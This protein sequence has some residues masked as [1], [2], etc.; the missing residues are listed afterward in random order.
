MTK[1]RKPLPSAVPAASLVLTLC[2]AGAPLLA[3]A[4]AAHA[5]A[6]SAAECPDLTGTFEPRSTEWIDTFYFDAPRPRRGQSPQFATLQR[7]GDGYTLSWLMPK[8][9]VLAQARALAGRDPRSYGI[10]LDMVLRDPA[11]PLP[12]GVSAQEWMNRTAHYGPVFR[13]DAA[14]PLTQ[15]EDG[16]FLIA[17]TPDLSLW[18]GRARDGALLLKRKEQKIFRVLSERYFTT[19]GIPLWSSSRQ[20]IWPAAAALD[21]TPLSAEELPAGQ[22]P[23]SRIAPCQ[24]TEVHETLFFQR[25]Q[26]QLPTGVTLENHSSSILSGRLRPDG[27][28]EPTPYSVTVA[29]PDAAGIAQVA[30]HLRSDPLI[31]R[32]DGQ[33]T[34][35]LWDGR[36]MVEFRMQ[37][38]PTKDK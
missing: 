13:Y 10:W 8:E 32:I 22:R 17:G 33:E 2:L 27:T 20:E 37:V 16:W 11:I 36:L 6:P 5:A 38:A 25:L 12:R 24:I 23:S 9:E 28:C 7:S 31:R 14:L 29:A 21:L 19:R 34:H 35:T 15:C 26:A 4:Q 30:D 1:M 3:G 18:L